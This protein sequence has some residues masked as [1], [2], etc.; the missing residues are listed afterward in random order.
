MVG[1][2][3][4]HD[5]MEGWMNLESWSASLERIDKGKKVME[6]ELMKPTMEKE[7]IKPTSEGPEKVLWIRKEFMHIVIVDEM[8][9][10]GVIRPSANP[11]LSP[12]L[13]VRKKDGGCRFCVDYK[14]LN[15]VTILDKFSIPLIEDLFDV[16]NG[17]GMFSKIDL[18]SGYHQIRMH[19]GD[20]ERTAFRT[21]EGHYKFLLMPFS[22]H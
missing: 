4:N 10:L 1:D 6:E 21:H 7:L 18:K 14:A 16:L 9:S 12:V 22:K 8:L 3:G 5:R 2:E 19:Q 20:I 15:N 17:V 13:L 11:C